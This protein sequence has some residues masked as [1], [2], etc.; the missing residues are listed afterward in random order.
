MFFLNIYSGI[1][2]CCVCLCHRHPHI[3]LPSVPHS[4]FAFSGRMVSTWSTCKGSR[5]SS[6]FVKQRRQRGSGWSSLT[7]PCEYS[8]M[9]WL[10]YTMYVRILTPFRKNIFVITKQTFFS[11][12]CLFLFLLFAS[13]GPTSSQRE[14]Q[15][16]SITSKCIHLTKTPTVGHARCC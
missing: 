4:L 1:T 14:P 9:I 5:D 15:Q 11:N 7:W 13:L 8:V 6:S 12:H 2:S 16:I 10:A 3:S